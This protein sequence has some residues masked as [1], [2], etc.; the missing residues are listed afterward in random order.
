MRSTDLPIFLTSRSF[1]LPRNVDSTSVK[2]SFAEGLLTLELPK[3]EE[4]RPRQIE[5][6]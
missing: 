5:I 4:S 6:N 3:K 1:R 2:A